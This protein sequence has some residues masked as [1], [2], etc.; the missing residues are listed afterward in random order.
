[1]K[2]Y[3]VTDALEISIYPNYC[4]CLMT[5]MMYWKFPSTQTIVI[6]Y[7]SYKWSQT[8]Y[9]CHNCMHGLPQ[10]NYGCYKWSPV[11]QL[12]LMV[13]T[14]LERRHPQE[15]K[16]ETKTAFVREPIYTSHKFTTTWKSYG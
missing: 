1:M 6:V 3:L 4:N 14:I 16:S 12:V 9:S 8:S 5:V 11:P 2:V 13:W 7:G 10:T 15:P